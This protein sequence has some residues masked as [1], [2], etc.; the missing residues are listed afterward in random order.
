MAV[1]TAPA[2]A[3]RVFDPFD[4]EPYEYVPV[5]TE[6]EL[7]WSGADT[8]KD[9]PPADSPEPL[10]EVEFFAHLDYK[11]DSMHAEPYGFGFD[12]RDSLVSAQR[13]EAE[14]AL[15]TAS[16]GL[17]TEDL[18][19]GVR[20]E[21]RPRN[22]CDTEMQRILARA[23]WRVRQSAFPPTW[24]VLG[25]VLGCSGRTLKRYAKGYA[26]HPH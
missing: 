18:R 14:D 4:E 21:G 20:A 8:D 10:S 26:D 7:S 12:V 15:R 24:D 5:L 19:L 2:P 9:Y 11:S 23:I 17:S 3:R 25:E 16:D 22:D 13:L 1:L 6:L